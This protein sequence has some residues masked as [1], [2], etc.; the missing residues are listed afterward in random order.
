MAT[1]TTKKLSGRDAVVAAFRA[2]GKA[3]TPN[4]AAAI[5][6]ASGVEIEAKGKTPMDYRLYAP[7][8]R[9]AKRGK[10]YRRV[11]TTTP[12]KFELRADAPESDPALVEKLK[13]FVGATPAAKAEP[14][15][16]AAKAEG[17]KKATTPKK[18]GGAKKKTA[19]AVA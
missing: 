13:G 14:A 7:I 10:L 2:A 17:A 19:A 6:I 8:Y 16:T 4:E 15:K 3:L 9:E 18:R 1:T 12:S 11:G 5:V